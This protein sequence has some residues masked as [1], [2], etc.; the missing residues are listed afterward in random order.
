MLAGKIPKAQLLK[1]LSFTPVTGQLN[2]LLW[3]SF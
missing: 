2:D 1:Q 3:K